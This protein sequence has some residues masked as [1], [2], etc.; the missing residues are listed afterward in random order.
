VNR[1]LDEDVDV[2]LAVFGGGLSGDIAVIELNAGDVN[3]ANSFE[4]PEAVSPVTRTIAASS[5]GGLTLTLPAHS[6][7]VLRG[8]L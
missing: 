3:A 2:D 8:S 7:T 5:D 4:R 1:S 6:H